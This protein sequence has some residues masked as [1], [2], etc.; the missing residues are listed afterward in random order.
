MQSYG[1]TKAGAS[2]INAD[3][4]YISQDRK[5]FAVADGASGAY[6]KT[7]AGRICTETFE[8][9]QY[10]QS[11]IK[12]IDYIIKCFN[13]ANEKLISKSREDRAL[14][15]GTLT[16]AVINDGIMTIG[17]VGDT[18]AYLIHGDN[19]IKAIAPKKRYSQLIELGILSETKIKEAISIIPNEMWSLFD[20]YLPM[21][22]PDIATAEYKVNKG[23]IL[24]ICT[25]GISDYIE[26][27]ELVSILRK[28]ESL[29]SACDMLFSLVEERCPV[30]KLDDR[31]IIMAMI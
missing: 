8:Y 7:A 9:N 13:E 28:A 29:E 26:E 18:P 4:F 6:D 24:I 22:I 16:A 11:K 14:S 30:N 17:A 12:Q 20:S 3:S 1:R 21:V 31:T 2:G 5:V 15:F 27:N 19:I 10:N 23:D 25:D